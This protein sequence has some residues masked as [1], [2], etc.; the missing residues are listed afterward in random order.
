MG[1]GQSR[2]IALVLAAM[3]VDEGEVHRIVS[4]YLSV[5]RDRKQPSN[6]WGDLRDKSSA[7][8]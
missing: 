5:L 8:D 7:A 1:P 6:P 2:H 4:G 3:Q